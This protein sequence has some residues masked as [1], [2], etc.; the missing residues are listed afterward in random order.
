MT[1]YKRIIKVYIV[2]NKNFSFQAFKNFTSYIIKSGCLPYHFIR[3]AGKGLNVAGYRLQW[4][5]QGFKNI[6]NRFTIQNM[7]RYFRNTVC[8]SIGSGS[9]NIIDGVLQENDLVSVNFVKKTDRR[10]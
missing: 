2:S 4:I 3:N 9:F 7:N 6:N 8:G 1:F 10:G 5:N